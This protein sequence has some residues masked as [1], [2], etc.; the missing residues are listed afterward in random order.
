M[1]RISTI[2]NIVLIVAVGI[3]YYLHFNSKQ[4]DGPIIVPPKIN[5]KASHLVY[6]NTDSLMEKYEY[7]KD[8]RSALESQRKQAEGEF[9]SKYRN[10]ENEANNLREIIEKLS[11]EE[12]ARQQQDIM[13]K[14][15][16]LGEFRDAMQERLLKNEQEKNE[17]MLKSISNFLEKNY[18]NTGYAYILGYQ[19]GGGIL[20]A[21][22]NLNITKEV[23]IGLN[24]QYKANKK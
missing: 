13:L 15:Q 8:M 2:L 7:V 20:Y 5:V 6:I 9:Q 24:N 3:L 21:K 18:A 12:A 23:L 17:E 10:L 11:Q 1:N 4:G 14:E 22:N 16:K 19:H